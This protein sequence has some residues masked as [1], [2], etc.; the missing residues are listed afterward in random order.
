MA[1]VEIARLQV[2]VLDLE[3]FQMLVWEL[4]MLENDM[5]VGASPFAE[6]L[7]HALDRAF[8]ERDP[9]PTIDDVPEDPGE[10]TDNGD[11]DEAAPD[12][13]SEEVTDA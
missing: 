1:E 6:R 7:T 4:R 10:P 13:D 5:R 8:A 3:P 9:D 2:S 12:V 11:D